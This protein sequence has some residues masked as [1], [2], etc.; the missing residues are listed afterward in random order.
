MMLMHVRWHLLLLAHCQAP[1]VTALRAVLLPC[2]CLA[3]HLP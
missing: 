1:L 2:A 3:C